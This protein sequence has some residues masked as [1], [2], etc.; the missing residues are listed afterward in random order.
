M[1]A[2]GVIVSGSAAVDTVVAALA[3]LKT[4]IMLCRTSHLHTTAGDKQVYSN[5]NYILDFVIACICAFF[6]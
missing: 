5:V 6:A 3:G 4:A 2:P 1:L